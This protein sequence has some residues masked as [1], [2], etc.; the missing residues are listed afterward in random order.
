MIK[1]AMDWVDGLTS[2]INEEGEQVD[3][4]IPEDLAKLKEINKM[5][6]LRHDGGEKKFTDKIDSLI[7]TVKNASTP[8]DKE[9]AISERN[10]YF[11]DQRHYVV[12]RVDNREGAIV[13]YAISNVLF[14]SDLNSS[15]DLIYSLLII[16]DEE[17]YD[18]EEF[19]KK[20]EELGLKYTYKEVE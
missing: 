15:D 18:V 3:L 13:T 10:K 11:E 14:N 2:Y 6:K 12:R 19:C 9:K 16:L 5:T 4:I 1:N 8:E 17:K 20:G 7:L